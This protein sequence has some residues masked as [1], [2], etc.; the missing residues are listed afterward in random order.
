MPPSVIGRNGVTNL[1]QH[2]KQ[3]IRNDRQRVANEPG[4]IEK[5]ED[6]FNYKTPLPKTKQKPNQKYSQRKV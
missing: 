3:M 2:S 5:E 4:S 1:K 6:L